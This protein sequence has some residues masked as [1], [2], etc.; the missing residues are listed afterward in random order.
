VAQQS[1]SKLLLRLPI[2]V[3]MPCL[4]IGV[5]GWIT[6]GDLMGR[7]FTGLGVAL[8]VLAAALGAVRK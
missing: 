3:G 8:L 7:V 6:N 5:A 4:F 2:F 1:G